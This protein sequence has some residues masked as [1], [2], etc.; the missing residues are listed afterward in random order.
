MWRLLLWGVCVVRLGRVVA[1]IQ[2]RITW[3]W[4]SDQSRGTE[5]ADTQARLEAT[6]FRP[7]FLLPHTALLNCW[8]HKW[9]TW[10][11]A[12]FMQ[13]GRNV[14]FNSNFIKYCNFEATSWLPL[15]LNQLIHHIKWLAEYNHKHASFFN[16]NLY[17]PCS[18]EKLQAMPE[19][20]QGGRE[21]IAHRIII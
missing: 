7:T 2:S 13:Y 14:F 19:G 5:A 1:A 11:C 20:D 10:T 12:L 9:P 17:L 4:W 15:P 16:V 21:E 8:W 6:G 18:L 3:V